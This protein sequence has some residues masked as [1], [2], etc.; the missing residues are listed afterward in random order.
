[1]QL[2]TPRLPSMMHSEEQWMW[3]P[4]GF[5]HQTASAPQD[6]GHGWPQW[7]WQWRGSAVALPS[8]PPPLPPCLCLDADIPWLS[9]GSGAH[10]QNTLDCILCQRVLCWSAMDLRLL[11]TGEQG[12]CSPLLLSHISSAA[13]PFGQPGEYWREWSLLGPSVCHGQG[14]W[15]GL[16]EPTMSNARCEC[17]LKVDLTHAAEIVTHSNIHTFNAL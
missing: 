10:W 9:E 5:H 6:G 2:D 1:M 4:I 17:K 14:H 11:E 8:P 15:Q 7:W 16:S 12:H 13:Q 3:V